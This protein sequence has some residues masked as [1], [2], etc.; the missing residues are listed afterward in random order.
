M[1]RAALV[2]AAIWSIAVAL[3]AQQTPVF[4]GGVDL[5]RLDVTVVDKDGR[6]VKGLTAADFTVTLDGQVRPVRALDFLEFG[7]SSGVDAETARQATNQTPTRGV[8][9]GGRVFLLI[10]DDLSCKP[11]QAKGLTIAAERMVGTFD[12]DD[13][14]GLIT[15]SGL[16]PFIQPTRDRAA[17]LTALKSKKLIGRYD[18][19]PAPRF[20]IA[21]HEA[22]DIF[23]GMPPRTL[24]DVISRECG[25]PNYDPQRP[26]DS[27]CPNLVEA[28]GRHLGEL[29]VHRTAMQMAAYREAIEAMRVAPKPRVIVALTKGVATSPVFDLEEQVDGISRAAAEAGV[30]FYAL[31]DAGAEVDFS[32]KGGILERREEANYLNGGAETVATAAGGES[33]LVIGQA[34]R[35]FTRIERETS[36][37]YQL[38]VEAP[39]SP[40]RKRLISAKVSVRMP[41]VTVRANPH[42]LAENVAAEA[43]SIDDRLKAALAQGGT[44]FG[45]PLAL[46]TALR[47]DPAPGAALQLGVDVQVP[48]LVQAPLVAMFALVDESGKIVQ[49]GRKQVPP[50]AAGSPAQDYQLALPVPLAPGTYRLRFAVADVAGNI[51]SVEQ[52][53]KATLPHFGR[54]TVSELFTTWS[55]ADDV[56]RFLA[57]ETLPDSAETL[58]MSIEIYPDDPGAALDVIVKLA[59]IPAGA[60]DPILE[61]EILPAGDGATRS[62][63]ASLPT[64]QLAPGAYTIRATIV[65]GG[66]VTGTVSSTI[67]KKAPSA[68]D[69]MSATAA[70]RQ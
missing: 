42:A 60:S 2:L 23:S 53:I 52:P 47:R 5:V 19:N 40:D 48:S 57:L 46:A 21:E 66:A 27:I 10:F 17:V 54:C 45:V 58:R 12:P 59:L 39:I 32:E 67:R 49:E 65:E 50:A 22:L 31:V 8:S 44:S 56:S 16:G 7:A 43:V 6:P 3:S 14:I 28:D 64:G 69:L 9:R 13:L 33:F 24:Y 18:D 62:A 25:M 51:G 26:T 68:I 30:Q 15:T 20:F 4:R 1:R 38:G 11:T 36:G 41:G 34:D 37:F 63:S 70:R 55:G 29:T 61:R 35:F